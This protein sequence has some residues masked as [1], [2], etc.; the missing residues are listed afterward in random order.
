MNT[1]GEEENAQDEQA[2][3]AKQKIEDNKAGGA[4]L[5]RVVTV[6]HRKFFDDFSLAELFLM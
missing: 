4:W 5:V 3:H 2:F 1:Q 6:G